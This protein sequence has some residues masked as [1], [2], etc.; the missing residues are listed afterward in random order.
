MNTITKIISTLGLLL[1]VS[2]LSLFAAIAVT[3]GTA[4]LIPAAF[5]LGTA[6]MIAYHGVLLLRN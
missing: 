4:S 5:M 1:I 3:S 2:I 6:L